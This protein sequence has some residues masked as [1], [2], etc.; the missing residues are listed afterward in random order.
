MNY[1]NENFTILD[2]KEF[3]ISKSEDDL[4]VI[5]KHLIS[6]ESEEGVELLLLVKNKLKELESYVDYLIN[7]N[8]KT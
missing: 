4:D 3:N 1:I 6:D 7:K 5:L 8:G 2:E